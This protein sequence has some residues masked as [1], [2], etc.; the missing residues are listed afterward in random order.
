MCV[1]TY[2]LFSYI[3][4]STTTKYYIAINNCFVSHVFRLVGW[5]SVTAQTPSAVLSYPGV[6]FLNAVH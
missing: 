5:H 3:A 1:F 2:T 6:Q 4:F